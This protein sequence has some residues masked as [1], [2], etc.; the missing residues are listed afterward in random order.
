MRAPRYS[1]FRISTRWR[2]PTESAPRAPR[3]TARPKRSPTASSRAALRAGASG[4]PQRLGAEHHVVEHR[5]VVRQREV[6]VHHAD[7][8]GERGAGIPGGSGAEASIDRLV[9][10]RSGRTGSTP[11]STCRRRSRRAARAPRRRASSSEIA[12]LA[13]SAPKRLV[14]PHARRAGRPGAHSP[15]SR[16]R[17]RRASRRVQHP[18]VAAQVGPACRAGAPAP[19]RARGPSLELDVREHVR[20]VHEER[21]ALEH[22]AAITLSTAS[23]TAS[24]FAPAFSTSAT[25]SANAVTDT[26]S[27]RLIATA[28][29]AW[30][31]A[32]T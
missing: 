22:D 9:G 1:A 25:P 31:F 26:T 11:A 32:P 10:R 16:G 12:S 30:P 27:A 24:R 7:A 20:V 17:A 4:P 8:R 29:I 15:R 13:T 28:R 21:A 23:T 14:M 5:Q 18:D 2:S 19:A 3:S 6:L